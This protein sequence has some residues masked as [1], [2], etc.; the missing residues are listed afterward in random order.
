MRLRA[1][2]YHLALF[3]SLIL[4][5]DTFSKEL[6]QVPFTGSVV[7]KNPK[8]I[9]TGKFSKYI[10]G[11]LDDKHIKGL[12]LALIKSSDVAEAGVEFGSWGMRTEDGDAVDPK[13]SST[14]LTCLTT[15]LNSHRHYSALAHARRL[16]W[17]PPWVS[18]LMTSRKGKTS[19]LFLPA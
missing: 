3:S 17:L 10:Q 4:L 5:G 7:S 13:V 1:S 16:F 6:A 18:S 19:L 2:R 11:V 9:I 14:P 12:S 15:W 8:S